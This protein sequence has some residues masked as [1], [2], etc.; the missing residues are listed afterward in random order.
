MVPAT[1]PDPTRNGVD[2]RTVVRLAEAMD[3]DARHAEELSRYSRSA[4]VRWVQGFHSRAFVRDVPPHD[5]DEPDWL[6]GSNAAMAASEAILGAVG[7]CVAVGFAANASLRDVTIRE[8]EVEVEGTIDLPSFFGL[9]E[10]NPGYQ[11][12][13]MT[14]FVDCDADD[15]L[16]Q[17][18]VHRAVDLSPVVNTMRNAVDVQHEV[19]VIR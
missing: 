13:R 2:L 3:S 9:R 18:I 7:G 14:L 6:G 11:S 16:L 8:L 1:G 19:K 10:G 4:R 12:L 15:A 5:Y 17:E